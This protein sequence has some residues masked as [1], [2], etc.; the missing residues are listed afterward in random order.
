MPSTFAHEGI[1][2]LYP[3]NWTV[4]AQSVDTTPQV[5]E[6]QSPGS[7]FWTLHIYPLQSDA[8]KLVDEFRDAMQE[9]YDSLEW[10]EIEEMEGEEP[11]I[12]YEMSFYCLDFLV[13]AEVRCWRVG[14]AIILTH[15]QAE[16]R[17]FDE[18]APIFR[19]MTVSLAKES[20]L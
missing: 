13:T 20:R 19:A 5:V 8:A 4:A 9:E 16:N 10:E 17:D 18:A 12:G 14:N 11:V 1:K 15:A 3:D 2:F 6:L 7:A